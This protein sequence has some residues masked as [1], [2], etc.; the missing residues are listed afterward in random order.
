MHTV[1]RRLAIPLVVSI[2]LMTIGGCQRGGDRNSVTLDIVSLTPEPPIVGPATLELRLRDRSGQPLTGLGMIEVEGTMTHA[3]ME[4]VIVTAKET[5]DGTYVTEGFR[6][7]MAG[8][9][10]ILARGTWEGRRFEARAIVAGVRSGVQPDVTPGH[11]HT[12]PSPT[13]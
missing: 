6:F 13:P 7:T 1:W 9:W 4:P 10:I 2:L 12:G 8:D 5:A 3:G 11:D